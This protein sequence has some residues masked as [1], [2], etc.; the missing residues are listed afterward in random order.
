MRRLALLASASPWT[1]ASFHAAAKDL[2][3]FGKNRRTPALGDS[4]FLH[5]WR[6]TR[7]WYLDYLARPEIQNNLKMLR[8]YLKRECAAQPA[9]NHVVLLWASAKM[10]G[11]LEPQQ[12][13]AIIT[14]ILG[15]QQPDGGE[16]VFTRW[17]PVA[18]AKIPNRSWRSLG[19]QP[20]R[21]RRKGSYSL[22]K[23]EA[24]HLTPSAALYMNDAATAYAVLALTEATQ[25]GIRPTRSSSSFP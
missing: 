18:T 8:E 20:I 1:E 16:P 14:G 4:P 17:R 11:L 6:A 21:T 2:Y 10:P 25:H 9:I 23:N 15:K 7:D 19:S 5:E 3:Y 12:R 24:Q 13:K 22:N